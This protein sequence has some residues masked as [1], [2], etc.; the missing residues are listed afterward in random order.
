MKEIEETAHARWLE[1]P[2]WRRSRWRISRVLPEDRP[3]VKALVWLAEAE[4]DADAK[5]EL[6]RLFVGGV[7]VGGIAAGGE[8]K[9][10][11]VRG[12]GNVLDVFCFGES[13]ARKL[14]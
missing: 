9:R 13:G 2:G 14:K 11:V 3:Y 4:G 10:P 5:R 6:D 7:P 8:C 1:L 12:L